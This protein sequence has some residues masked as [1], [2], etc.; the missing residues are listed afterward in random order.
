M[1]HVQANREAALLRRFARRA[2]MIGARLFRFVPLFCAA[3]AA[4]AQPSPGT[5]APDARNFADQIKSFGG[6]PFGATLEEAKKSWQLEPVDGASAPGDPVALYLREEDSLVV[7]GLMAREVI[8]YFLHEKFYA[9]SFS[10]P[11]SRQTTIL[12]EALA[13]GYG[14]PAQ[15]SAEGD[16]L[17]WPGET[18]SAHLL[19]Y[20]AGEARV[21]LFGNELQPEYEK[22]LREAAAQTVANIS[23]AP[24]PAPSAAPSPGAAGM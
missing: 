17:V 7:G 20:P 3:V 24:T 5:A 1:V 10:T 8:Y 13:A 14:A 21:V 11:D 23:A 4:H 19:L 15:A 22:C 18:V 9:V 6:V 12:R 2:G 16:S